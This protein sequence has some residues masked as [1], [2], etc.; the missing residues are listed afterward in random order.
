MIDHAS[1]SMAFQ[2]VLNSTSEPMGDDLENQVISFLIRIGYLP[3]NRT[4]EAILSSIPYRLFM[5]C[6]I[7]RRSKLWEID[8]L[9]SFLG[10]TR[11][12]VYRH[13][14]KLKSMN[15][16]EDISF[17]SEDTGYLHKG[18]RLRY[19]NLSRAWNVVEINMTNVIEQYRK[20]VDRIQEKL[21]IDIEVLEEEEK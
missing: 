13:L 5:D 20:S 21:N 8:Q 12:T 17:T 18:Y 6:F 15:L 2:I 19:G 1:L 16:V 14:N 3:D 10:T 7:K 9:E 11:A 4:R